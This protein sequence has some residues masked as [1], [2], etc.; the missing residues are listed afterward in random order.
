MSFETFDAPFSEVKDLGCRDLLW[1]ERLVLDLFEYLQSGP[2]EE[3]KVADETVPGAY[4]IGLTKS[5]RIW[6]L[7]FERPFAV[8]VRDKSL[9][10]LQPK[11]QDPPLPSPYCF[12]E[13][14]A[15]LSELIPEPL[16]SDPRLGE[17]NPTHYI[18]N[19]W[20]DLIE[21]IA[22]GSPIIEEI[23]NKCTDG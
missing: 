21:I 3:I 22:D 1:G 4:P 13:K 2:V 11:K 10:F 18:F 6:Q 23:E 16:F 5:S 17:L 7:T 15:W 9:K 19:L 20:D 8:R 12:T 14:S